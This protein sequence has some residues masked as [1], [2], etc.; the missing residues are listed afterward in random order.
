MNIAILNE[1]FFNKTHLSRL[2]K[3]GILQVYKDTKTEEQT[4]KRIKDV[5]IAIVDQFVA[6]INKRVIE[7]APKLKL[8]ALN[9]TS[10]SAVDLDFTK[11][12]KIKVSN[13]PGFSKQ[14]VAELAIGLMFAVNRKIALGD[15][16]VRQEATEL[17]PGNPE[18]QKFIGFDF[19]GKTLG[20]I[21]LGRIGSVVAQIGQ[22]IGM[23]VIAYN[24]SPKNLAGVK[25]VTLDKLLKTSDIV[26]VH[27]SLSQ[28]T[29]NLLSKKE[30]GKLKSNTI[31]INVSPP[32]II[33]Q[34]AL[35][36]ALVSRK[37]YGAGIDMFGAKKDDPLFQLD[38]VVL[39]PHCGSFTKEA[40][41]ENLPNMIVEN[42]EAFAKG[43]PMNI[44]NE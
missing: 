41:F 9:S 33:D 4:I 31:I 42:V 44:V 36:D 35:Y 25:M 15:K 39:T 10:F 1:C 16:I 7:S 8:L 11:K 24:R 18:H 5:D 14:A 12:R 3:L 26:S 22:A 19:K 23:K 27:L 21:G 40:F 20:I 29:K 28:E 17:D 43:K 6:P 34:K 30:I 2:K 37:I 32:T 13:L 38:N